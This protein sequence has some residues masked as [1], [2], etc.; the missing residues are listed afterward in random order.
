MPAFQCGV[1]REAL[2]TYLHR[3]FAAICKFTAGKYGGGIRG[4]SF[5]GLEFLLFIHAQNR[6]RAHQRLG[7]G[8]HW[9][10]ENLLQ[11]A[12]FYYTSM[13]MTATSSAIS[14]TMP[15]LCVISI[16]EKTPVDDPFSCYTPSKQTALISF[17]TVCYT[18]NLQIYSPFFRNTAFCPWFNLFELPSVT[19]A[20]NLCTINHPLINWED[21]S[22]RRPH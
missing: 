16:M 17:L 5:N 12:E 10:G 20:I 8:L 11:T 22:R 9:V 4:A 3:K 15:I 1:Y 14:T 18:F 19:P 2:F 6:Y 7:V 13:Y 21:S